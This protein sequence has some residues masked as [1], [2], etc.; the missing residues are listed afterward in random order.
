MQL[1][2]VKSRERLKPRREPYWQRVAVGQSL[3]YRPLRIG[4]AGSWIAKAYDAETGKRRYRA[5]GEFTHL[6]SNERHKA[7]LKEARDWFDHIDAG[8]SHKSLT[9]HQACERYAATRPDAAKRF[10]RYVYSDP[11]SRVPLQKLTCYPLP[12]RS[13]HCWAIFSARL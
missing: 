5:L 13:D 1:D 7:A 3:G 12:T 4:E 2:T 6:P 9:V 11:I 8:G 10:A